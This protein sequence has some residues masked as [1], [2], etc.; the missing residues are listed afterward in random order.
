M[1]R[2]TR[3]TSLMI[4]GAALSLY[5][6]ISN[7]YIVLYNNIVMN[8]FVNDKM[9]KYHTNNPC[10]ITAIKSQNPTNRQNTKQYH[11]ILFSVFKNITYTI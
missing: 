8:V 7:G 10:L 4:N 1:T 6:F 9:T 2:N 3:E 5:V 11:T